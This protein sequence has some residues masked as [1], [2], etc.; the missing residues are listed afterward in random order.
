M[1]TFLILIVLMLVINPHSQHA[2]AD[3]IEQ[4]VE[5]LHQGKFKEALIIIEEVAEQRPQDSNAQITLAYILLRTG[6]Y[7]RARKIL[8][9]TLTT[10][11]GH[12]VIHRL[13]AEIAAHQGDF[14]QAFTEIE[15]SLVLAPTDKET[16]ALKEKLTK[17]WQIE[18]KM[19]KNFGGNFTI[20]F[21]GGGDE[22]GQAALAV[23]E[24]AYVDLGGRFQCWP[25][26]KTEVILYGNR[27]FKNLTNAPDW[28][29]GLYDGKIRIPV[30]GVRVMNEKLRRILYHEYAH[31]LIFRLT[32]NHLPLWLNEGL[33]QWFSQENPEDIESHIRNGEKI[34]SFDR[35]EKSFADLSNPEAPLAYAQS[36]SL[37]NFLIKNFG[38]AQI[39]NV[40]SR[41]S[42]GATYQVAMNDIFPTWGEHPNELIRAWEATLAQ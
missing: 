34:I 22:I 33:A 21:E 13:L 30:G 24:E 32:R 29:G 26:E 12:P 38:E 3:T 17:E 42:D 8:R 1:K 41:I 36:L 10:A 9:T 5:L 23:L 16:L 15:Q 11:K 18:E 39:I 19:N 6:E 40:L 4:G 7:E 20:T 28:S 25:Q 14:P 27:D 35:L 2:H 37:T 31:V